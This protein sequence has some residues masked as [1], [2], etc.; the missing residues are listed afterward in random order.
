MHQNLVQQSGFLLP[1]LRWEKQPHAWTMM[2]KIQERGGKMTIQNRKRGVNGIISWV[3]KRGWDLVYR[4]RVLFLLRIWKVHLITG[5]KAEKMDKLADRSE[6]VVAGARRIY[7]MIVHNSS[8]YSS[9][10]T[11]I[12]THTWK[13]HVSINRST[14]NA[15]GHVLK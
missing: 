5:E 1:P 13:W 9:K 2:G 10:H 15:I 7:L 12:H 8:V 3:G 6:D 14:F 11:H 4:C